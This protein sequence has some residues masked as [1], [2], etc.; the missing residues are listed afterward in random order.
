VRG[1]GALALTATAIAAVVAAGAVPGAGGAEDRAA[2]TARAAT[3]NLVVAHF[4][5]DAARG[6]VY[7]VRPSRRGRLRVVASLHGLAPG[8][9]EIRGVARPCSQDVT[10]AALER[11]TRFRMSASWLDEH[12]GAQTVRATG[13]LATVRSLRVYEREQEAD[14]VQRACARSAVFIGGGAATGALVG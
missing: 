2:R 5:G 14:V 11:A 1:R 12:Y 4:A 13:R 6:V 7:A 8:E 9:Y 3:P 10:G